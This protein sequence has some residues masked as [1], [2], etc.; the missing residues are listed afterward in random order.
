M[1]TT[2]TTRPRTLLEALEVEADRLADTLHD[3][4]L[5]MLVVA[6]YAADA[7]VRGGDPVVTRDSVQD[8]L[9]ALRRLRRTL[10]P[11]GG[12][13]LHGALLDLSDQRVQAGESALQLDLDEATARQLTPAT[14]A[15]A[16]RFVQAT[17][18]VHVRLWRSGAQAVLETDGALDD[19]SGWELR[20][21][22]LGGELVSTRNG[23]RLLLPLHATSVS[24][25]GAAPR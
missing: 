9:V 13:D 2:T 11:R 8:A 20:A 10:R 4:V 5:Q 19:P 7:A 14:A 24:P 1:S 6:R 17:H 3:G 18:A 22:A 25:A 12:E 21:L 15:A 23:S 16:Y